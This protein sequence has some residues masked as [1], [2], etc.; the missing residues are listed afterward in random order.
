LR[1]SGFWVCR[2]FE[3]CGILS[4][5]DFEIRDFVGEPKYACFQ[6]ARRLSLL[7][8]NLTL[9][10]EWTWFLFCWKLIKISTFYFFC[11]FRFMKLSW[12][13]NHINLFKFLYKYFLRNSFEK[14]LKKEYIINFLTARK[15]QL[16]QEKRKNFKTVIWVFDSF[17]NRYCC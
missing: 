17:Y 1:M 9:F 3:C 8:I 6:G 10:F 11:S 12:C 2:D 5:R 15:L 4:V 16:W 13:K 7:T 14:P